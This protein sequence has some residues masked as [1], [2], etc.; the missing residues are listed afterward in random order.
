MRVAPVAPLT[1]YIGRRI[2]FEMPSALRFRSITAA[3]ADG[4]DHRL[5][6][7]SNLG[8]PVSIG[9]KVHF[10]ACARADADRVEITHSA[11]ASEV[12]IP[13]VEVP[14]GARADA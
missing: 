9:T 1:S 14:E 7:S 13:V 5:T 10:L 3:I 4:L 6:I 12:T 11:A 2:M 8:E